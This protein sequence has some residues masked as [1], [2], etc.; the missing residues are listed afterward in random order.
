MEGANLDRKSKWDHLE[1]FLLL[2]KDA[3]GSNT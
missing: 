1:H 2:R 3:D